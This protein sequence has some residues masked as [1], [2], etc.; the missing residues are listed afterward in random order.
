MPRKSTTELAETSETAAATR[1]RTAA[2]GEGGLR[3]VKPGQWQA[4]YTDADGRRR[5]VYGKTR[6]EAADKLR[7]ALA[8]RESGQPLP[9][10]RQTV[11]AYLDE[12]LEQTA[13]PR[14]RPATYR[15]YAERVRLYLKP[16]LGRVRLRDLTALHV[17]RMVG[18]MG[19]RTSA[20]TGRPLSARSIGMTLT[21]LHTALADALAFR[22][23][24]HNAAEAVRAPS[25][26]RRRPDA[27]T[28]ADA[29]RLL[30]AFA[31]D[32]YRALVTVALSLGLRQGEALGLRWADVD[33][34]ARTLTVRHQIQRVD[35]QYVFTP[36]KSDSSRRVVVLPSAIVEELRAHRARQNEDR[37]AAGPAWSA[38]DLVFCREDGG[39]LN[40]TAVTKR[41]QKVLDR[42]GLPAMTFHHLRHGCA[43]LLLA[44]GVPLRVVQ[45]Q[46]GHSQISLTANT[47]AHVAPEL[48]ADVADRMDAV[49]SA[50]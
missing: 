46:L 8:A 14:V 43:T 5:S 34:D 23:V 41:F 20:R 17:Q 47:Y 30:D 18:E 12:W 6:K 33:L 19:K 39:P 11:A 25:A 48:R 7:E 22:L 3:E 40:G 50:R 37:L 4:R 9:T 29:R 36:P 24:S 21:V 15:S 44:Q 16:Q 45:D 2:N 28:V 27:L 26:T 10:G 35:G 42:A 13:K 49:L 1:K 32:R 31:A 38:L